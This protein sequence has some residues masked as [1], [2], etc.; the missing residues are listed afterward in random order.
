MKRS[1]ET[2]QKIIANCGKEKK[3]IT[4]SDATVRAVTLFCGYYKEC[5]ICHK[6]EANKRK[7]IIQDTLR[8]A[9]ATFRAEINDSDWSRLRQRLS[10]EGIN[11]YRVTLDEG[12][13]VV[14]ADNDP[15]VKTIDFIE[16]SPQEA[17]DE[18]TQDEYLFTEKRRGFTGEW[19]LTTPNIKEELADEEFI[20]IR[21]IEPVFR[22]STDE[23]LTPYYVLRGLSKQA[24]VWSNGEVSPLNAQ[25]FATHRDSVLIEM[26][27]QIGYEYDMKS[28]RIVEKSIPISEI[29]QWKVQTE[30][31][32]RTYHGQ[33]KA[34]KPYEEDD[35]YS[36]KDDRLL[37]VVHGLVEIKDRLKELELFKQ[38][39]EIDEAEI[40]EM[41]DFYLS[42][43]DKFGMFYDEAMI[44]LVEKYIA[45]QKEKEKSSLLDSDDIP[46]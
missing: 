31:T 44:P 22:N 35:F 26:A 7:E 36:T 40:L 45:N 23:Y 20:T 14:V 5:P 24:N 39:N 33:N 3:W 11:C 10:K 38:T 29:E 25:E 32:E 28:S 6:F 2:K 41:A 15:G 13:S 1:N 19:R 4:Q 8:T 27:A 46:F 43:P 30:K 17:V 34:G 21:I 42:S 18:L 37:K 16:V 9:N 12:R